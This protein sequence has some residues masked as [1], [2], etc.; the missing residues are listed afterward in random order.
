MSTKLKPDWIRVLETILL[1]WVINA[2]FVT[3][4]VVVFRAGAL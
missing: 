3:A 1:I 2:A 4:I